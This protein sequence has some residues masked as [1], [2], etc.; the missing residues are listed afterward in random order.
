MKELKGE[1]DVMATTTPYIN[2]INDTLKNISFTNTITSK[3]YLFQ[4]NGNN[5]LYLKEIQQKPDLKVA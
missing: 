5:E 2:L 1:K 3:Q 4:K